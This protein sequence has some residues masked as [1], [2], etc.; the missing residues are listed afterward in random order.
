MPDS[1]RP[2]AARA[3]GPPAPATGES[4]AWPES[5]DRALGSERFSSLTS[6][7]APRRFVFQSTCSAFLSQASTQKKKE[8]ETKTCITKA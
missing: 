6:C 7:A 1:A 8:E 2:I 5:S 4:Y 3:P